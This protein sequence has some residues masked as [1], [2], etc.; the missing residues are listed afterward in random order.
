MNQ[1]SQ[2]PRRRWLQFSLKTLFVVTIFAAG[3]FAGAGTFIRRAQQLQQDAISAEQ[4]A[5]NAEARARLQ[6]EQ[7]RMLAESAL[8]SL[9]AGHDSPNQAMLTEGGH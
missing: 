1:S 2:K 4:A 6:A 5:R 9:K 3:Y 7:Q 8:N